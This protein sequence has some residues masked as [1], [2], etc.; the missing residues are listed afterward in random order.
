MSDPIFSAAEALLAIVI[1]CLDDHCVEYARQYVD[2]ARPVE[3]C[4]TLAVVMTG[5]RAFSGSCVG[6]VQYSTTLDVTLVRCCE[7]VG[8]LTSQSGY[9]PP[10][11]AAITQAVAC[12]SRD[13]SAILACIA[14]DGCN[15]LGALPG[16]SSCCDETAGAPEIVWNNPQGGCRSVIVRVPV[17]F[18]MCCS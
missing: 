15:V 16:V 17:N 4:S 2:S 12:L 7:P 11:P 13:A 14:C 3:D 9:T 6:R 18:T 5:S 10:D 8:E 1:E